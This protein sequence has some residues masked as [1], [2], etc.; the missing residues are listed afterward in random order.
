MGFPGDQVVDLHELE[1]GHAPKAA[2]PF[3]LGRTLL[4]R[5]SPNLVCGEEVFRAPDA[6]QRMADYR[7]G[8][9]VHGRGIDQ[10]ATRLEEGRR[11]FAACRAQL[12]VFAHV[13]GDPGAHAHGGHAD[14]TAGDAALKGCGLR[15]GPACQGQ[16]TQK[17]PA[18]RQESPARKRPFMPCCAVS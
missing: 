2:R 4:G 17:R 13:E 6:L 18:A 5:G 10:A 12:R 9:A 16:G 7:L 1:P 8:G 11:H 3:N 14:P 15:R